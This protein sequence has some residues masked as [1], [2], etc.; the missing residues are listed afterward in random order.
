M[1][2]LSLDYIAGLIEG[3]GCFTWT[4]QNHTT[5]VPIFSI[6]MNYRDKELLKNIAFSLGLDNKIYEYTHQ[7]RH[8][9]LLIVRDKKSLLFKVI[10]AIRG[11]LHGYKKI[12]MENWVIEFFDRLGINVDL[13]EKCL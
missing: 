4:F 8:Y 3:E 7:N 1:K 13:I 12:Q 10:P 2:K 6:K 11:S 9:A 5:W